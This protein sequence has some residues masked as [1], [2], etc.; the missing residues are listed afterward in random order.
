M[1]RETLPASA[2]ET[3]RGAA[4]AATALLERLA[5]RLGGFIEI[6]DGSA[7]F[8]P[9]RDPWVDVVVPLAALA[10]GVCAPGVARAIAKRGSS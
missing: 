3:G 9:I 1:T 4:F 2:E 8:K 10:V 6:K 5:E 7:R